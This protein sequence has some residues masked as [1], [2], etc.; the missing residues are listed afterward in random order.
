MFGIVQKVE[1]RIVWLESCGLAG[2][3]VPFIAA[4]DGAAGQLEPG[5]RVAYQEGKRAV[6]VVKDSTSF[7]ASITVQPDGKVI[8]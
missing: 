7:G 8:K 2:G 5:M 3:L 4:D 6:N 1:G